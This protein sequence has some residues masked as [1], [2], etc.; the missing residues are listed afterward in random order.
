MVQ[1]RRS[2]LIWKIFG[3]RLDGWGNDDHPT[4]SV[5]GDATTL[6]KGA[7]RNDADLDYDGVPC[8]PPGSQVP[9]LTSEEKMMFARW[10]DLGAPIDAGRSG[11]GDRGWFSDEIRPALTVTSPGPGSNA[12]PL[13]EILIGAVDAN[14]GLDESTLSLKANFAIGPH[15][16]GSELRRALAPVDDGVW[17]LQLEKPLALLE[18]GRLTASVRDRQGNLAR[19]ERTFTVE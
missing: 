7:D 5:P 19:I 12:G 18:Q 4:E 1:S 13:T 10:I 8:P 14:S 16:P 9:S 6:P 2:L 3:A 15:R 17:R 11:R